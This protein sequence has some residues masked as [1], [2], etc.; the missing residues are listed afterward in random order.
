MYFYVMSAAD[1]R[2]ERVSV[3]NWIR[4]EKWGREELDTVQKIDKGGYFNITEPL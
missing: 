2:K 4:L 3:S 1:L